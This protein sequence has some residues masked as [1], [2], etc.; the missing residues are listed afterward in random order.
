MFLVTDNNNNKTQI[1]RKSDPL[2][3]E[4]SARDTSSGQTARRMRTVPYVSFGSGTSM[5]I[6]GRQCDKPNNKCSCLFDTAP[7]Q[8]NQS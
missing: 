1:V 7:A 5:Y 3:N 2:K 6:W 4:W 8:P